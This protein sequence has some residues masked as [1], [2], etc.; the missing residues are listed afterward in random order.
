MEIPNHVITATDARFQTRHDSRADTEQKIAVAHSAEGSLLDVDTPD[1]VELRTRRILRQPIIVDALSATPDASPKAG[2]AVG[3]VHMLERIIGGNN[4]LGIAFLEL[5]TAVSC[6]VGRVIVR[7]RIQIRGFGTGFLI[8]PRLAL[9]N[10]HVL[11]DAQSARFSRLEF[12]FQNDLGGRPLATSQFDLEPDAF[13]QTDPALDVTV[14]AVAA[15]SRAD[16]T[17]SSMPLAAFGFNRTSRDQGKILLGESINIIQHP[18]GQEKQLA[19]QQNE[20]IDRFDQFLHY[21]TDTSPGS[22]GSP[23]YNNQWELLGLHHSGVPARNAAGDILAADGTVWD[24]TQG[25]LK[26]QWIANEGIRISS[27]LAWLDTLAEGMNTDQRALLKEALDPNSDPVEPQSP[28]EKQQSQPGTEQVQ[29]QPTAPV[30][31][32]VTLTI[33]LQVTVRLGAVQFGAAQLAQAPDTAPPGPDQ[34]AIPGTSGAATPEAIAIDPDYAGRAGY[35]PEFLHMPVPLP[36]LTEEQRA[37]VA[38]NRRAAEGQ[39][40]TVL[41]YHHFSLVMHRERRLALYTVVNVDG[42]LS[43]SPKRDRDRWYFD[44]RLEQAEQ[45]GE[46]LYAD[47]DFDRGHLVRRLD[48]AWG[49]DKVARL[50]NDDTF[51]FTNCSPQHKLFNQGASLWAGLEDYLLETA[52]ADKLRLTLFT[53]PVLRADDP[54]FQGVQIPL[55][56][57]KIP[58]FQRSDGGHSASAYMISQHE[59]VGHI[60]TESFTPATFQVP[61]RSISELTGLNFSHLFDWDPMNEDFSPLPRAQEALVTRTPARELGTFDD[62]HL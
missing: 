42:Q 54:D 6:S 18:E 22:S 5:G 31:G 37:S 36:V 27:I 32:E 28:V 20:L 11:P 15:Q 14:V 55:A 12:N 3:D 25:E 51:H 53:G 4:L 45:I 16:G 49:P 57:W 7:D 47:N 52:K 24:Q 23:L 58:V 60:L 1:R 46:D 29:E 19:L 41:P 9:T 39:D 30:N 48:P 10:N 26:I 50:A 59:L 40:A 61:V 21:H 13:F 38:L 34:D 33:P 44:P 43:Q 8:S 2:G 62:L 56:F 17:T 35:D